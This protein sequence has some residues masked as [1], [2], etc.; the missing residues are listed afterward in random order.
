MTLFGTETKWR[1]HHDCYKTTIFSILKAE[2]SEGVLEQAA[3][4][5]VGLE[6]ENVVENLKT[7]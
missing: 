6:S 3:E 4:R 1:W 2:Q 5:T 7:V